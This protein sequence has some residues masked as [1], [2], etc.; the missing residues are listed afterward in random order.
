LSQETST[1]NDTTIPLKVV[2][3]KT[4]VIRYIRM[5]AGELFNRLGTG[6]LP[7][8]RRRD[9]VG[10]RTRVDVGLAAVLSGLPRGVG[11]RWCPLAEERSRCRRWSC[12]ES[13]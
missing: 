1:L 4:N 11:S 10:L 5:T 9:V 12:R 7:V 2:V 13:E 8:G 3:S 6:L